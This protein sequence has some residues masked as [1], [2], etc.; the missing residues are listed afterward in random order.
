VGEANF[1]G[2]VSWS[3]LGSLE[4]I[5]EGQN[6]DTEMGINEISQYQV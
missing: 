3:H 4:P 1:P 2:V 5:A 6:S